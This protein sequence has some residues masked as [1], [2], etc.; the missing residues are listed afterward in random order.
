MTTPC[1][2][3][4]ELYAYMKVLLPPNISYA[5]AMSKLPVPEGQRPS[6]YSYASTHTSL[7]PYTTKPPTSPSMPAPLPH[8]AA[9]AGPGPSSQHTTAMV[10]A[11]KAAAA[12]ANPATATRMA[13]GMIGHP[14]GTVS[15]AAC[16][17]R[18]CS[19]SCCSC[20][21]LTRLCDHGVACPQDRIRAA[22]GRVV[23]SSGSHRVMGMLAMSRAIGDHY[24]RPYVIAEP[25]V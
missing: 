15:A 17:C 7:A 11:A 5:D 9:P 8:A 20:R 13:G 12:G 21:K 23:F 2:L 4:R 22:G 16:C 14:A 6:T 19:C 25:E 10:A 18:A 3:C 1:A 24:L